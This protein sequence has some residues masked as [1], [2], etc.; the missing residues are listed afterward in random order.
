[1]P[2]SWW[3]GVWQLALD[4]SS[5]YIPN[6]HIFLAQARTFYDSLDQV[7]LGWKGVCENWKAG[8]VQVV[9][10]VVWHIWEIWTMKSRN[11]QHEANLMEP[12]SLWP[13][14]YMD[15]HRKKRRIE[16]LINS[17]WVQNDASTKPPNLFGL[18]SCNFD[19]MTF[20][21]ELLRHNWHL[22]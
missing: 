7:F 18:M 21:S 3:I 16:K 13:D 12:K 19:S 22:P 2:L 20:A 8:Y 6:L 14:G 15:L 10:E 5:P 17:T 1:M 9:W 4:F 11:L